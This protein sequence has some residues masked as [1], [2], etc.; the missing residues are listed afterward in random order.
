MIIRD[1]MMQWLSSDPKPEEQ[2]RHRDLFVAACFWLTQGATKQEAFAML[3][4]S[5]DTL[6]SRRIPDREI[7]GAIESALLRINGEA[8]SERWPRCDLGFRVEA[9]RLYA[10]ERASLRKQIPHVSAAEALALLYRPQDLVC[11]GRTATDFETRPLD[12]LREPEALEFI[13][14][15]PMSRL[16]GE[17]K[18]GRT[19]AHARSNT[20]PRVYAVIEF[21][22]GEWWEHAALHKFLATRL[23]LVMMVHS[24]AT[25]VH[26]WFKT[27]HVS[28]EQVT[29]FYHTAV[30]LGA[31]PKMHSP[32][33]FSRLPGG[34]HC[35]GRKQTIIYLNPR[36]AYHS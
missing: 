26:G 30:S 36:H 13:N 4:R 24:G 12:T 9:L 17:T 15:S 14:P 1:P 29:D 35:S 27:S 10:V 21:D 34:R 6:R 32:C 11:V 28:E 18:D 2:N 19:S 31:D 22:S 16:F 33:Q 23:P 25:S 3:R 7:Y 20:G 8:P 5:A